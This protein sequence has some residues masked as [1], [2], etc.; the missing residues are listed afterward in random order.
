MGIVRHPAPRAFYGPNRDSAI[1]RFR[2]YA[3][4]RFH[5]FIFLFLKCYGE[6]VCFFHVA[7]C[8][9]AV[10]GSIYGIPAQQTRMPTEAESVLVVGLWLL[11]AVQF[12]PSF[13][14]HDWISSALIVGLTVG[15]IL[16]W[17]SEQLASPARLENGILIISLV[18]YTFLYPTRFLRHLY[19]R[20]GHGVYPVL[21]LAGETPALVFFGRLLFYSL[22]WWIYAL[23][24]G[25]ELFITISTVGLVVQ[26]A[27]YVLLYLQDEHGA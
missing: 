22:L 12:Y 26:G 13:L 19:R 9:R 8:R 10:L 21:G 3:I 2:D 14:S 16:H 27:D 20:Y 11:F 17:F 4:L 6:P 15:G 18:Q 24:N 23:V 25:S 5:V 7:E 1:L